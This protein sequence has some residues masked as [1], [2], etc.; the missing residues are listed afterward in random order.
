[1]I[2]KY[3]KVFVAFDIKKYLEHGLYTTAKKDFYLLP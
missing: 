3:V 1:M 2:K